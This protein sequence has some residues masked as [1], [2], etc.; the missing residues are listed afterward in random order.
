[1]APTF[2][3]NLL[4]EYFSRRGQGV[5]REPNLHLLGIGPQAYSQSCRALDLGL[6]PGRGFRGMRR[7]TLRPQDGLRVPPEEVRNLRD[8]PALSPQMQHK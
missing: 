5:R 7:L 6:R 8:T 4:D 1:M 2:R 3:L